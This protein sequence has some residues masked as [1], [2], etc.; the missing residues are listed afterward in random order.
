[1][2]EKNRLV[3]SG[4]AVLMM[5]T[6][7]SCG[8][9]EDD[10]NRNNTRNTVV[11]TTEEKTS[12]DTTSDI[13][14]TTTTST[15]TETTTE[16]STSEEVTSEN[17]EEAKPP[18]SDSIDVS[19]EDGSASTQFFALDTIISVSVYGEN[20]E[21]AVKEIANLID[22]LDAVLSTER[23][24]S[25]LYKLNSNGK[26]ACSDDLL[27]VAA[28]AKQF[29]LDTDGAFDVTVY[30]LVKLW[31]FVGT[32]QNSD[33]S[34][35]SEED[36]KSA[37]TLV[38]HENIT[39]S[40]LPAHEWPNA[41][42][43]GYVS[44]GDVSTQLFGIEYAGSGITMDFGAI[45]KG[46]IGDK[47]AELLLSKKDEGLTG[48]MVS[49]GGNIC[50]I[51]SKP[52]GKQWRVGIQ[53][54]DAPRGELIAK[55]SFDAQSAND[56][57]PISVVTSGTYERNFELDGKSYHHILDPKTGYPA[58]TDLESVTVVSEDSTLA[59]ALSTALIVMGYEKA[60]EFWKTG[61]YDFE[62]VLIDKNNAVFV[63]EGLKDNYSS[64]GYTE[65]ISR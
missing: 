50:F 14:T 19:T 21:T 46:Y 39:I 47:T 52:D 51:G 55:L 7:C 26:A 65:F 23:T 40:E 29:S 54:P 44:E 15:D 2:L 32:N 59:D 60:V 17:T 27:N 37:L 56:L 53:N 16:Q 41:Y 12:G 34:V 58:E 48:A 35:P 42:T 30:P 38:N 8:K 31:G 49:L 20:A 9:K 62:M 25:E 45:G 11:I 6:L 63:T 24:D 10:T 43:D 1:M 5:C 64:D 33:H 4:A 18:F 13:T 36:I 28:R 3:L 57:K 22:R 61:P